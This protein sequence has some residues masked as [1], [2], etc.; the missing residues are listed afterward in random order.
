MH[1]Q[2]PY[3]NYP[4]KKATETGQFIARAFVAFIVCQV[5]LHHTCDA[6]LTSNF[7]T[8]FVLFQ[9][10]KSSVLLS[11]QQFRLNSLTAGGGFN[12]GTDRHQIGRLGSI[13][14]G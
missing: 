14:L 1:P 11:N 4:G 12:N 8:Q 6:F 9:V 3:C 5:T 10:Q 13:F 2:I 7:E